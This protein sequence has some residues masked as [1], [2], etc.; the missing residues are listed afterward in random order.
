M[1]TPAIAADYAPAL[2]QVGLKGVDG[3][4]QSKYQCDD[5]PDEN[6]RVLFDQNNERTW[7]ILVVIPVVKIPNRIPVVIAHG[8]VLDSIQFDFR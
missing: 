7:G 5:E 8:F 6:D 4:Y 3:E 1:F 2:S